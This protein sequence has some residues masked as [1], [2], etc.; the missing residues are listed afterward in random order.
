[1]FE[2]VVGCGIITATSP[3]CT[4]TCPIKGLLKFKSA[5]GEGVLKL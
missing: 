1:M 2:S 4:S 3:E 5:G